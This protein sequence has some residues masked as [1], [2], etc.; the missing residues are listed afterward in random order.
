MIDNG[1]VDLKNSRIKT[2][3]SNFKK[4]ELSGV[5]VP[6]DDDAAGTRNAKRPKDNLKSDR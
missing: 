3:R 1:A 6:A 5:L 2:S 4:D